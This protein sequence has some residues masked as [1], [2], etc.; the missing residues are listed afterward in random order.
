MVKAFEAEGK[1][2][3]Y[4]AADERPLAVF[5]LR[6]R[7]RPESAETLARLRALDVERLV[8][9]TGDHRAPASKLHIRLS[10]A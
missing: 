6:D 2:L 5:A 7:L 3:L 10:A 8:M 9:I 4:V 1:S